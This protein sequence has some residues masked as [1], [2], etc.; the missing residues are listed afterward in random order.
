MSNP[1]PAEF[2]PSATI[3]VDYVLNDTKDRF[4][5]RIETADRVTLDSNG[6]GDLTIKWQELDQQARLEFKLASST[7]GFTFLDGILLGWSRKDIP[8]NGSQPLSYNV[9][10]PEDH[11][12]I[13]TLGRGKETYTYLL[14]VSY[15]T[16]GG[17]RM[18]DQIDPKIYNEGDGGPP[19]RR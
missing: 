12:L 1:G 11:T 2:G 3:A 8:D 19:P 17:G 18:K 16:Q 15:Q 4:K 5:F 13:V 10:S 9:Q 7:P 14:Y 6:E